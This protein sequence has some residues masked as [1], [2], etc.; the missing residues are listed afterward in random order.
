MFLLLERRKARFPARK[1]E[2][3]FRRGLTG[4][5]FF[6]IRENKNCNVCKG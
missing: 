1:P 5:M 3:D 2:A 6:F 4:A